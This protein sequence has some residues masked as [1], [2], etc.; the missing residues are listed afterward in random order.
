MKKLSELLA[1]CSQFEELAS[2]GI[3][4]IPMEHPVIPRPP[5]VP[6]EFRPTEVPT[7]TMRSPEVR[8]PTPEVRPP[9]L[10]VDPTRVSPEAQ[11]PATPAVEPTK[12]GIKASD[13]KFDENG[14]VVVP[15]EWYNEKG[16]LVVDKQQLAKAVYEAR[17]AKV[18]STKLDATRSRTLNREMSQV[19]RMVKSI[20]FKEKLPARATIGLL[21]AAALATA[22]YD[23]TGKSPATT[24]A[25]KKQ[26]AEAAS[27]G[28]STSSWEK[29][30]PAQLSTSIRMLK[31]TLSLINARTAETKRAIDSYSTML[32][33]VDAQLQ[34][35]SGSSL[36]LDLT[37]SA[38]NYAAELQKFDHMAVEAASKLER[39]EA[40]FRSRGDS[41]NFEKTKAVIDGLEGYIV[42]INNARAIKAQG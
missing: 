26:V 11:R 33:N 27:V 9:P 16:K 10:E 39:L 42:A 34:K 4:P 12:P 18:V 14:N 41:D 17:K 13:I 19:N 8:V 25:A 38:S 24:D 23:F 31:T 22:Y 2:F 30:T 7:P 1:K 29:P 5:L 32:S 6:M 28:A 37:A 36:N 40:A 15:K 20:A 3:E 21:A 35:L